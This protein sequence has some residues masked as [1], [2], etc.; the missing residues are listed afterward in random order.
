MTGKKIPRSNVATYV[1]KYIQLCVGAV[2]AAVGLELFLIPN[3][4]IDGGVVGLSIMAQYVTDLPLGVFLIA[5]NIPFLW[6][7][8]KQIGKSFGDR[9]HVTFCERI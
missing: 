6:L 1:K 5:F 4:V 9:V 3:E 2:I 8:Y 7:A